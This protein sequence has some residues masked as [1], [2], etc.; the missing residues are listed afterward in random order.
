MPFYIPSK[1][2]QQFL[3]L[4]ILS[5]I[6]IFYDDCHPN[7]CEVISSGFY[8]Y[9]PVIIDVK[10]F[11]LYLLAVCISLYKCLIKPFAHFQ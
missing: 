8:F 1:S 3:F 10:Y 7:K 4:H 2:V 5:N 11:F 6:V 9:F